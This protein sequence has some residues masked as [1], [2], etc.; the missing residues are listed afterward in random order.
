MEN[1][2]TLQVAVEVILTNIITMVIG[3]IKKAIN[4][5]LAFS[6]LEVPA[7]FSVANGASILFR[8]EI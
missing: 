2:V 7:A 1:V 8:K 4:A 6:V 3:I 5:A